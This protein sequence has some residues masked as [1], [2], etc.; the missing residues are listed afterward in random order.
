MSEFNARAANAEAAELKNP[1]QALQLINSLRGSAQA[2]RQY[3]L[4]CLALERWPKNLRLTIRL[5]TLLWDRLDFFS[6]L[7]WLEGACFDHPHA[8]RP[9]LLIADLYYQ[10]DNDACATLFLEEAIKLRPDSLAVLRRLAA[11]LFRQK[12]YAEAEPHYHRWLELAPTNPRPMLDLVHLYACTSRHQESEHMLQTVL[13][14]APRH[15]D[16]ITELA[17]IFTFQQRYSEA[18]NML[19][20]ANADDDRLIYSRLLG[21]LLVDTARYAEAEP[22]LR[23]VQ[24]REPSNSYTLAKLAKICLETNRLQEAEDLARRALDTNQLIAADILQALVV[25]K[26]NEH[27]LKAH[28]ELQAAIAGYKQDNT[29]PPPPAQPTTLH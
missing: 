15:V 1:R 21:G 3:D 4:L 27:A 5:A 29:A 2:K 19:R 9:R 23:T 10:V 18:E 20:R 12:R 13:A 7:S 28:R 17:I 24:E 26:M 6:A 16:A 14:I 11:T 22:M 8:L 25:P